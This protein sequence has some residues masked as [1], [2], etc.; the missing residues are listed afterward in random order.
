MGKRSQALAAQIRQIIAPILVMGPP[1]CGLLSISSVEVSHDFSYAT[2]Y[3]TALEHLEL[4]ENFFKE[5]QHEL[6][7]LPNQRLF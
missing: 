2:V 1:E 3:Y 5:R 7:S 4:A 6:Q